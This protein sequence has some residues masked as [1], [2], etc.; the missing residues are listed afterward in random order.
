MK[1]K[2]D[3]SFQVKKTGIDTKTMFAPVTGFKAESD[4]E[5]TFTCYG[6]VK[7]VVDHVRDVT[8]DGA[9][10]ACIEDHKANGTMPKM[11]WNHDRWEP[12]VGK[13]LDMEEDAKGL[14][15]RGKF[16]DTPRGREL[17]E[18]MKSGAL[19][20]FSIG[21]SVNQE[22]WD[23]KEQINELIEIYVKEVSIV[24]FACNEAS[25]LEDIKNTG[26]LPTKRQLQDILREAGLSKRQAERITNAYSP[27]TEEKDIYELL[28][29]KSDTVDAF[30]LITQE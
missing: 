17:Y 2:S 16:A 25:T 4:Q 7:N 18:L 29:G 21:Y 10:K 24:N 12:P 23:S 3:R 8:L 19:D 6:N 22:R 26:D 1:L 11:L 14:F 28:C 20:S 13:W 9:F 27:E 30:D 15:M 5:M